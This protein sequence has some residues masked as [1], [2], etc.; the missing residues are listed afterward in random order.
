MALSRLGLR[1]QG[2]VPRGPPRPLQVSTKID[3]IPLS[4][5]WKQ[6]ALTACSKTWAKGQSQAVLAGAEAR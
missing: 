1:A 2:P 6:Q 3:S 5:R 4:Q